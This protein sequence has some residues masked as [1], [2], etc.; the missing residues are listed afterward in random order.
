MN[1]F[2]FLTLEADTTEDL[3]KFFLFNQLPEVGEKLELV[4]VKVSD[5]VMGIQLMVKDRW[6][7]VD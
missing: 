7:G 6:N 3:S 5:G 4:V 2:T 1:D